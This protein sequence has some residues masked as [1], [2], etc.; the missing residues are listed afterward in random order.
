MVI[1]N[2]N[3]NMKSSI[4]ANIKDLQSYSSTKYRDALSEVVSLYKSRK[5]ENIRTARNIAER[6]SGV[7][8]GST[9]AANKA[10]K[11]L[12]K[13]RTYEPATGKIERNYVKKNTKKYI[14]S[15]VAK[16]ATQYLYHN[17]KNR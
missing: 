3:I 11:L 13:Y 5:I 16:V 14:L 9:G 6:L 12:A 1:Y 17:K 2:N 15:G 4:K 10:V 7:G 8:K